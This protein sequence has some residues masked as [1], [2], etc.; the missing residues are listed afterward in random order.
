MPTKQAVGQAASEKFL[1]EQWCWLWF[2]F[3]QPCGRYV[4]LSRVQAENTDPGRVKKKKSELQFIFL[5]YLILLEITIL[6]IFYGII[7]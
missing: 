1:P 3:A 2:G 7:K 4:N 5:F 6:Y